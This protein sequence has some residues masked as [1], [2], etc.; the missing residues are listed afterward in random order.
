MGHPYTDALM[1]ILGIQH[2]G[3]TIPHAPMTGTTSFPP[4]STM[5]MGVGATDSDGPMYTVTGHAHVV[6]NA[7]SGCP[8][9]NEEE[10]DI[11]M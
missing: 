4:P 9:E 3:I 8:C 10:I 7:G 2:N 6:G 1:H 5:E 11:D